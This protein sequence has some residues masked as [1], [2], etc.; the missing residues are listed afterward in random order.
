MPLLKFL[1]GVSILL[2]LCTIICGLWV[3]AHPQEDM[4]FHFTLSL[5]TVVVALVTI[6]LFMIKN[7][8]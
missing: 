1:G 4:R 3:H 7:S 8:A 6:I 2:L 5:I